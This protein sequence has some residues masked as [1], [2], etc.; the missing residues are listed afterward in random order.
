MSLILADFCV[1][2]HNSSNGEIRTESGSKHRP[3]EGPSYRCTSTETNKGYL[4]WPFHWTIT[5]NKQSQNT[6][7]NKPPASGGSKTHTIIK[8]RMQRRWQAGVCYLDRQ[9]WQNRLLYSQTYEDVKSYDPLNR[10]ANN[11]ACEKRETWR[12]FIRDHRG[13]FS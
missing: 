10:E 3:A 2:G 1:W 8:V 7:G 12:N 11:F 6:G 9:L 5:V 4:W 13:D